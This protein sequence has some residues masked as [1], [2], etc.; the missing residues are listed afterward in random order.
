MDVLLDTSVLVAYERDEL[1]GL[2]GGALALPAIAVLEYWKG[3]ERAT[4]D[5]RRRSRTDFFHE[6]FGT[7]PVIPLDENVA[8]TGAHL[9]SDLE[10]AGRLIPPFD[11]LVAAT[12]L[13]YELQLATFDVRHFS[14]VESLD[15]IEVG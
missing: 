7:L 15:L 9:W 6:A 11:L 14:R 2:P 5:S 10:R 12:A 1:E 13:A 8:R 3:V 4:T